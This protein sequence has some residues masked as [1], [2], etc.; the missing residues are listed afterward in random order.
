MSKIPV[1]QGDHP[2]LLDLAEALKK[3]AEIKST[4]P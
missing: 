1:Q 2:G 4:M 3:P